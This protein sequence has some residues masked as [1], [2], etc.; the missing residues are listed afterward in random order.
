MQLLRDNLTLWTSSD[1]VEPA[2][3]GAADE[4]K[5]AE[6]PE[7]KTEETNTEQQPA[8]TEAAPTS[9]ETST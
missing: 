5:T 9:E 1:G 6:A 8:A 7:L 4:S 3:D 2:V